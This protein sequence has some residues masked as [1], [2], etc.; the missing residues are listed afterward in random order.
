MS[1]LAAQLS[2]DLKEKS[3]TK[4]KSLKFPLIQYQKDILG[5]TSEILGVKPWSKQIEILLAV[6]DHKRITVKSGHKTGK[7]MTAAIIALWFYCCFPKA[8]VVLTATT[9]N[10]IK[11]ILWRELRMIFAN[12]LKKIDGDLHELP[13][14]G[15]KSN[16]FREI[17][18]FTAKE[19]EGMAGTSGGNLLYILDEA[20]G[21]PDNIY[22]AIEGNRAAGAWVILFSNPTKKEGEFFL[23]HTK[24]KEFYKCFTISS[25]ETPNVISGQN[26]IPGLAIKDYI[27]EKKK[28]WG[29]DS[30]IYKV[31]ITG[32]FPIE[33]ENTVVP[34]HLVEAAIERGFDPNLI[35]STS[36][37]Y[38]GR[39]ILGV[40]VARFGVDFSVIS[41]R[42]GLKV[43]PLIAKNGLNSIE[44]SNLVL[45]TVRSIVEVQDQIPL[46]NVDGGGGY[47]SGLVDR[48]REF[49]SE[50]E[51]VEVNVS[52]L[53][54]KTSQYPLLRDE[55]WFNLKEFL[56]Q[57]VI[58]PDDDLLSGDLTSAT[59]SFDH[60]S[61]QKVSSK[62]EIKKKIHRSPDR[63][64]ALALTLY[65]YFVSK[66]NWEPLAKPIQQEFNQRRS[67][68]NNIINPYESQFISG[69]MT[70]KD[71]DRYRDIRR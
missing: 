41:I 55:L 49:P 1:N 22:E 20:S 46:V 39:L 17:L 51:V 18:G 44:L 25:E 28:E 14:S 45:S 23:S 13:S 61:R 29:E 59:Y 56:Q 68:R 57:E 58:L 8:R 34:I 3:S 6:Q 19:P 70:G 40:D 42:R 5:F 50:V 12:S 64:D 71:P 67:Y 48:L 54:S 65:K 35:N 43:Y 62:D 36:D 30:S 33:G 7:S 11:N 24:K 16:D 52:T 21:I 26:L 37:L 15:L 2:K 27:E 31:R 10:Q 66:E 47:G 60:K 9:V 32:D 4:K 63:A 69:N 38:K 53:P